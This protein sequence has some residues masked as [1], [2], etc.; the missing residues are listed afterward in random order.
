MSQGF[1]EE[2]KLLASL[3]ATNEAIPYAVSLSSDGFSA[4][5]EVLLYDSSGAESGSAYLVYTR[6]PHTGEWIGEA[7][8]MA[9]EGMENDHPGGLIAIS[10]HG[11]LPLTGAYSGNEYVLSS[12]LVTSTQPDTTPPTIVGFDFSPGRVDVSSGPATITQETRGEFDDDD[13]DDESHAV[14]GDWS[15]SN[16]TAELIVPPGGLTLPKDAA[17]LNFP[18]PDTE[19]LLL[20]S[21]DRSIGAFVDFAF[22]SGQADLESGT[23]AIWSLP[24]PTRI[25]TATSMVR[26]FQK[27]NWSCASSTRSP[28]STFQDRTGP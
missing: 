8:A 3:D 9:S 28:A 17:V 10:A 20:D 18:D 26:I 16:T 12:G 1:S 23:M 15:D 25:K 24:T 4:L 7:D 11:S 13:D 6:D 5:V 14:S 22:A 19:A 27:P 21:E 2:A